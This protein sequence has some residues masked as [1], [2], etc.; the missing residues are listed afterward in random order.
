MIADLAALLLVGAGFIRPLP[1]QNP[2]AGFDAYVAKALKESA[3]PGV[4]IAIVKDDSVVLLRGYG[5]RQLGRPEP[6]TPRTLFEIGSTT[7]AFSA[8]ILATPGSP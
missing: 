3:V 7:K 8:A 2:L 4:A 1:A 6:V 5:L